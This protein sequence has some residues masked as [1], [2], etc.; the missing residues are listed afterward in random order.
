MASLFGPT[1]QEVIMARQQQMQQEQMLRNQQISQ[2]GG[3]FGVFAPLYQAGLRFGDVASQAVTQGLFPQQA[4][5]ALQQASAIQSVLGKYQDEDLSSAETLT[6]IGRELMQI[7]P[8]AGIK[9]LTLAGQ[10]GK[11]KKPKISLT[12]EMLKQIKPEDR[13]RVIADYQRTGELPV[14]IEWKPE[15]KRD[16]PE[17][18]RETRISEL[19]NRGYSEQFATDIVDRNVSM[20]INPATGNVVRFNKLTGQASEVPLGELSPAD[21]ATILAADEDTQ[22]RTLWDAAELGTGIGSAIR[23][24]WSRTL[25]QVGLGTAEATEEARQTLLTSTNELARSLVVNP[26]FPVAEVERVIKEAGT[27]PSAADSPTLM[28]ARLRTLDSFLRQRLQDAEK[29]ANNMSLPQD[30]RS[31]QKTNAA[32]IRSFLPKLGVPET[33]PPKGITAEQWNRMSPEQKRLFRK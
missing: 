17:R 30:I 1:P 29:D 20:E 13:A 4:D 21:Q 27:Q 5:P 10:L 31:A 18:I 6:K 28:R 15:E 11:E 26:R 33:N 16:G 9:A 24:G 25:G 23:S 12:A 8:E 3:Q 7:A 2:Q 22:T 19:V 14:G 32:A